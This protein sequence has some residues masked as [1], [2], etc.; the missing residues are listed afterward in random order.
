MY[1]HACYHFTSPY[2]LTGNPAGPM[3]YVP[4]GI[5]IQSGPQVHGRRVMMMEARAHT[6]QAI[7]HAG[8]EEGVYTHQNVD[9]VYTARKCSINIHIVQIVQLYNNRKMNIEMMFYDRHLFK[10]WHHFGKCYQAKAT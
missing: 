4:S 7:P 2:S 10:K 8:G 6:Y 5:A 1:C 3:L 9:Y